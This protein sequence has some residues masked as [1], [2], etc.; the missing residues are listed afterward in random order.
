MTALR[1]IPLPVH[2]TLRLMTGL[3]T[4]VVP[5]LAGFETP[6]TIMAIVVGAFAVG[7]ALVEQ[8]DERG[9]TALPVSALH[10]ADWATVLTVTFTAALVAA[11]GDRRAGL[12][13]AAI[14]LLQLAGNLTT[15]YS[16]RA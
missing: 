4:M 11:D 12:V 15:R 2:A 16:L 7:I 3:L 6:A 14:G 8:P 5:F 1:L 13:L 10:A 9:L